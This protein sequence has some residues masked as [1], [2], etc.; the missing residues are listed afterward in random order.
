MSAWEKV[1]PFVAVPRETVWVHP[2]NGMWCYSVEAVDA[3]R[4]EDAE[5]LK[6]AQARI[7]ELEAALDVFAK[8]SICEDEPKACYLGSGPY[9]GAHGDLCLDDEI[10]AARKSLKRQPVSSDGTQTNL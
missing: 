10:I 5:H 7:A 2:A 6:Q 8:I 3:A 1:T 9:C 4:A